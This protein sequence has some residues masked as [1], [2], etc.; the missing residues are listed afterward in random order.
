[1][2]HPGGGNG[3]LERGTSHM[4]YSPPVFPFKDHF[5]IVCSTNYTKFLLVWQK[6]RGGGGTGGGG[7][8]GRKGWG[9]GEEGEDGEGK[10][11]FS[12]GKAVSTNKIRMSSLKKESNLQFLQVTPLLGKLF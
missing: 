1:M 10:C 8:G 2:F 3:Q 5:W 12:A 6:E 11:S 4:N 9:K 7:G